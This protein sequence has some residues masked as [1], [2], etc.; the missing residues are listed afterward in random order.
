[1]AKT[2][3]RKTPKSE[4]FRRTISEE[5][6][7]Q[8]RNLA[9]KNDPTEIATKLEISRP[10]VNKALIYGC[11]HQQSIVDGITKFFTDRILKEKEAAAGLAQLQNELS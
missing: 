6:F 4:K 2:Q 3:E 1:M 9:R 10:T 7:Q 11:C 8:W 5:L